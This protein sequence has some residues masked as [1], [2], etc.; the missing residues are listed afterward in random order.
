MKSEAARALDL[1]DWR[2]LL[3]L[4]GIGLEFEAESVRFHRRGVIALRGHGGA[5]EHVSH[6]DPP[7]RPLARLLSI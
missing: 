5:R 7:K 3:A 1:T 6:P 4:R 2:S